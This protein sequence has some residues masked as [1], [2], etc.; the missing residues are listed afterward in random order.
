VP[1]KEKF[2]V[3]Y[4]GKNKHLLHQTGKIESRWQLNQLTPPLELLW[5]IFPVYYLANI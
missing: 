2:M 3:V 1:L 5:L 4:G